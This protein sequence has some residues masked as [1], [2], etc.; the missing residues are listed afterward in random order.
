VNST[1]RK[2]LI[3]IL[4]LGLAGGM[5]W[6]LY[7]DISW[8]N[9]LKP[10][11]VSANWSLLLLS[12]IISYVTVIFRGLRWNI[13]LEPMGYKADR[14][15][16]I[17]SV[18]FGYC[19]NNLIPRSGELARCTLIN[20]A[21]RVPVDKLIGTVILERIVDMALLVVVLLS[22]FFLHTDALMSLLTPAP[23]DASAPEEKSYLLYYLAIA[24]VVGIL[25]LW[26]LYKF[27][28][29]TPIVRRAFE[30]LRGIGEGIKTITKLRQQAL[31]W[32]YSVGIWLGWLLMAYCSMKALE[33]TSHMSLADTLFFMAAGS[34][35][36]IVP[37]PGGAGAFHGMS[38]LAF[39]ALG[40]K[41]DVGKIYAMIS[42]SLKT[43]FDILVGAIGFLIVTS[44]KIKG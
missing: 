8:E 17:H 33:S 28:Q 41:G 24:G 11:L 27:F 36:M 14:W 31:F 30:F 2:S 6:Y 5:L 12:C 7:M 4:F 18:A 19:M 10:S 44:K 15:T 43:A 42:W 16:L 34:L 32:I 25:L 20:R 9:D 38:V 1:I 40:Y 21:E 13:M 26:L 37:T 22:A 29:S 39:Q 35:G 3:Y 23:T